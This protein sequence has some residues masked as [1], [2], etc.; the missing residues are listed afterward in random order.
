[1]VPMRRTGLYSDVTS[2]DD[3]TVC[4][5]CASSSAL[6]VVKICNKKYR[7]K[8]T[9]VLYIIVGLNI[10]YATWFL[11]NISRALKPRAGIPRL[12][13]KMLMFLKICPFCN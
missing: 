12:I 10:C 2:S 7:I 4:S 5:S 6:V 1:M 8:V 13:S 9:S 11:E 3:I